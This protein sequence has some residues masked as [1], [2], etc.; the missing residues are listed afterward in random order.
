[1]TKKSKVQKRTRN[2]NTEYS[3]ETP[4]ETPSKTP[5]YLSGWSDYLQNQLFQLWTTF[6]TYL[7]LKS[8]NQLWNMVF[9]PG[10]FYKK[11]V[12]LWKKSTKPDGKKFCESAIPILLSLIATI[13]LIWTLALIGHCVIKLLK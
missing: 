13:I 11:A 12:N 2:T 9:Y 3:S 10:A 5:E 1:M 8:T 4:P 6:L 7:P